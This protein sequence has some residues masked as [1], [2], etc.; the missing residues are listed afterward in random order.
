MIGAK[1]KNTDKRAT[2][3]GMKMGTCRQNN[4]ES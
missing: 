4:M 1:T 2:K 3:M